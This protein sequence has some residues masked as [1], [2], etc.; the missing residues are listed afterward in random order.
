MIIGRL[1]GQFGKNRIRFNSEYQHRCEGTPLTRRTAAAATAAAPTGSGSVTTR[2]RATPQMSPEATST[3]ATR[4]FRRAV[5][6]QPG[7]LDDAGEQ[8]A[9]VGGRLSG[10]PLPADLR[11]PAAGRHH[12]PDSGD[13]AVECRQSGN[14][15]S[16]T[17]RWPNYR[18]RAVEEWGPAKGNTDDIMGAASYVTGAHNAKIGYQY[19]RLDLLDDD[20]ANSTQLGYVFNRGVP[21]RCTTTCPKWADAR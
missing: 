15:D 18:Y 1:T 4:L 9:A 11:F 10:I 3:A 20:V 2:A 21:T 14:R 17:R 6:H 8:Q 7:H 16:V 13:R 19:R 5:L 12:Q